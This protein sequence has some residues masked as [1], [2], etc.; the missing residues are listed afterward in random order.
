MDECVQDSLNP[1]IPA[2]TVTLSPE[3]QKASIAGGMLDSRT[4]QLINSSIVPWTI[5][6]LL[7][8]QA[9]RSRIIQNALFQLTFTSV[10]L[11]LRTQSRITDG[12]HI[13][14]IHQLP[15]KNLSNTANAIQ[16]LRIRS[17][18]PLASWFPQ[19]QQKTSRRS[20]IEDKCVTRDA[21]V[22][23]DQEATPQIVPKLSQIVTKLRTNYLK[24][25]NGKTTKWQAYKKNCCSTHRKRTKARLAHICNAQ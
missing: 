6:H 15:T 13:L 4:L 17:S 3:Y 12:S 24:I 2:R 11:H 1:P 8:S 25:S 19:A 10:N 16:A 20:Q 5:L 23:P 18:A 9:T 22:I 14:R 7:L 21:R